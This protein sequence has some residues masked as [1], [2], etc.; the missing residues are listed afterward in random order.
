MPHKNELPVNRHMSHAPPGQEA[1]T[2]AKRGMV[3]T[4]ILSKSIL[5]G[6]MKGL[7]P[8]VCIQIL[9]EWRPQP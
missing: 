1:L 9:E 6:D 7:G 2:F 8:R 3:A 5:G 4:K